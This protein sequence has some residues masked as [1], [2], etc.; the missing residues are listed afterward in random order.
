[1]FTCYV[2]NFDY[3]KIELWTCYAMRRW[4][5]KTLK[6]VEK[7]YVAGAEYVEIKYVEIGIGHEAQV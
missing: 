7:Q 2:V 6:Y 3:N 5:R 4:F 1:M